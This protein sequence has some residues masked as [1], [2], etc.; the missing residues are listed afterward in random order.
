[1]SGA[2]NLYI[3]EFGHQLQGAMP[4]LEEMG[5][6]MVPVALKNINMNTK[7]KK[8]YASTLNLQTPVNF[9]NPKP[10]TDPGS[11]TI[12]LLDLELFQCITV[13]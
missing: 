6:I 8:P 4:V 1:M 13:D 3:F 2:Q 5:S 9:Q 11:S 7:G 12:L 10:K